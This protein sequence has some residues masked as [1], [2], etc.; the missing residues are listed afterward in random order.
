MLPEPSIKK[1]K[2][3][4]ARQT[5]RRKNGKEMVMENRI[6]VTKTDSYDHCSAFLQIF[7]SMLWAA[8]WCYLLKSLRYKHINIDESR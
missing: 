1:A 6:F 2:S 3:R 5:V 8:L 4:R 7:F